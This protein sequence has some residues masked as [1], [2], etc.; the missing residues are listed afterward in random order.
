MVVAGGRVA[1]VGDRQIL[2]RWPGCEVVDL[3]G[4]IVVPGFID[5]HS[6]LCLAALH[7]RWADLS[8]TTSVDDL[9]RALREQAAREPDADWVRGAGWE[10]TGDW[11]EK[12]NRSDLDALGLDRPVIVTHFSLH[13][14]VVCSRGLEVLGIGRHTP[15][16][17]G[18]VIDRD[19]GGEPTGLLVERAWSQAHA[20]S[21]AAYQDPD[22][23]E[24]HLLARMQVLLS[25]GVTCVH[26]AAT[27]P[28]AEAVYRRLAA[29]G[30]LPLSVLMM[31]HP[32][33][34]LSRPDADRLEGPPTGD[35]DEW[36][37]VGPIK[38]FADGGSHPAIDAQRHGQRFTG[39]IAFPGLATDAAAA[40]ARGFRVAVHAMGNA[41][42]AATLDAFEAV[43]RT[44]DGDHRFRVE[45]A[46]LA[47]PGQLRRLGELGA[48]AVV[49]PG[50]V[51]LVGS[52]VSSLGFDDVTW[53]P[54]ADLVSAGVPLAASSD[55]PCGEW[56]P[57]TT[58]RYGA[59]RW[60]GHEVLGPDQ[61]LGYGEWLRAWTAGSAYAGGQEDERGRLI[62][63][64]RAD[65]VIL[66]GDLDPDHPPTVAETWVAGR[67]RHP[68][69][70][71][72]PTF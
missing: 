21:L 40:A 52:R 17:D 22:Q 6:H 63:G 67:R 4:R 35:G 69:G 48:V 53:M 55:H 1:A 49:Q 26:D 66:D 34:I 58:S 68:E 37:R 25:E 65:L 8:A 14:C 33:A 18:G 16:P 45:H 57:L 72:P 31:P 38:L 61:A 32:A 36:L 29:T 56:Q 44:D 20:E 39:G 51:P 70:L 23:W 41:G 64:A 71:E 30:R 47:S 12:L 28:A 50:F 19:A 3:G 24:E 9:G 2:G 13:M 59:S 11:S 54:F 60:T 43:A 46:T 62:P 7:P 15:D 42:L 5:A 27:P 10:R